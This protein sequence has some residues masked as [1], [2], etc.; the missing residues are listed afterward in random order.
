MFRAAEPRE[1][2][3]CASVFWSVSIGDIEYDFTTNPISYV[4]VSLSQD[5]TAEYSKNYGDMFSLA[6]IMTDDITALDLVS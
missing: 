3:K 2:M 1:N 4:V 5:L 6:L